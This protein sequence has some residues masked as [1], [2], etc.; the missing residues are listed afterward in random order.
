MVS[1]MIQHHRHMTQGYI[2]NGQLVTGKLGLIGDVAGSGKTLTALGFLGSQHHC[3]NP[4]GFGELH[5]QSN[6]FFSSHI[7]PPIQDAS[8]VNVVVVPP[9][10]LH[11]WRTE[12]TQHT[13]LAPFIVESRR[14][15]RNRT[16]PDCIRNSH[17]LLLSS[18]LYK[19]TYDYCQTHGISWNHLF[20]DEASSIY[21][22]PHDPIPSFQFLWLL[23]SNWLSFLFK[24]A[25]VYS[26]SLHHIRDRISLHPD[27]AAW[28][29]N[30]VEQ[31][32]QLNTRIESSQYFKQ[33]IPW[34]HSARASMILR[35][36]TTYTYPSL[37]EV[38]IECSPHYTLMNLP[39]KYTGPHYAGLTHEVIPKLF[40]A[41][42]VPS[43]TVDAIKQYNP[44]R[45]E[46]IDGKLNDDCSICLE[47]PQN[48]VLVP[49]CMNMSCGA[50][51]MRQLITHAQ[52]P[53]CR[54]PMYLPCLLPVQDASAEQLETRATKH[55]ACITLLK[56]SLHTQESYLIYTIYEN[57]YYQLYPE[58]MSLGISCDR[59]DPSPAKFN[60]TID[61]F[62]SG[63]T[64]VLFLTNLDLIR[65][66][67][68]TK[69]THILFFYELQVYERYQLLLHSALRLGRQEPLTLIHLKALLD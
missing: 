46:L 23:T 6:R 51:M 16:T 28:L 52:C 7:L 36:A 27:C 9:H 12:V 49:C 68:L 20:I 42:Q 69:A 63:K 59:L 38:Q 41:L 56:K 65:G 1:A 48:K 15:L 50:C 25:F 26:N 60:K 64:K 30:M 8:S 11:Q 53:S 62:N 54:A 44:S 32:V 31:G 4:G 5:P 47:P 24:D 33:I 45:K 39:P 35:N 40:R 19:D 22:G 10:L 21:L 67:S 43:H 34:Q 61:N 14:I 2:E 58:L 3:V 57:T 29:N 66:L 13:T 17:F 18:R 37:Q 55:D